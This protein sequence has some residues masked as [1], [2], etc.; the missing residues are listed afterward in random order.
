MKRVLLSLTAAALLLLSACGDSDDT[1]SAPGT[2]APAETTAAATETTTAVDAAT[3]TTE[4]AEHDHDHDHS[5]GDL[6]ESEAA[7]PP[8]LNLEL[9]ED[10]MSGWNLHLQTTNYVFAPE[11]VSTAHIDG[12]G[13]AHLYI[14]GEK[15]GRIYSPWF[16]VPKLEPGEHTLTVELSANDHRAYAVNGVKIEDS[17]TLTVPGESDQ[18]ASA[19]QMDH[20]DD[21]G[22]PVAD[23]SFEVVYSN[24]TVEGGPQQVEVE[25]G[26]MVAL[27]VT[28]DIDEEIHVH[29]YDE[30]LNISAG[31]TTTLIFEARIP[32]VFEAELEG[33]GQRLI[34]FEVS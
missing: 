7:E 31:E 5:H 16:E 25:L 29:G 22:V 4:M 26:S 10:P 20:M 8:T 2:S 19:G 12:Q 21:M 30:Y 18:T 11:N 24:G 9:L 1:T 32:G 28:S 33:N 15:Y 34:E 27:T 17:V 23:I 6:V 3:E 14:D 13:H